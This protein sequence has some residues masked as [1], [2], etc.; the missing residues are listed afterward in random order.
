MDIFLVIW[1]WLGFRQLWVAID[2]HAVHTAFCLFLLEPPPPP[3]RSCV[4]QRLFTFQNTVILRINHCECNSRFGIED[5]WVE[6]VEPVS[7]QDF[8]VGGASSH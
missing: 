6:E 2:K 1:G 8:K 3:S 5:S 7:G 4:F